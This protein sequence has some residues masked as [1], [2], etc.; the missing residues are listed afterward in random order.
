MHLHMRFSSPVQGIHTHHITYP[1]LRPCT[2]RFL[3]QL[4]F[5]SYALMHLFP[6]LVI[7]LLFL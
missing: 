2:A 1:P 5:G 6:R 7:I 4:P 3:I